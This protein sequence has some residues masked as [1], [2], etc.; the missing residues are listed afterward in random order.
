MA[1]TQMFQILQIVIANE[2][3]QSQKIATPACLKA[4]STC[5][6]VATLPAMKTLSS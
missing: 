4:T 6:H 2:V 5:R 1:G 3:K